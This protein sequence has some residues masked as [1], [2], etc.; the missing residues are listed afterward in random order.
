MCVCMCVCVC[1]CVHVCVCV[2]DNHQPCLTMQVIKITQA[3]EVSIE[4]APYNP[5]LKSCTT[6]TADEVK[7]QPEE[8][9]ERVE[10]LKPV[11]QDLEEDTT[12]PVEPAEPVEP[13]EQNGPVEPQSVV[14][15]VGLYTL[16]LCV[17]F[18]FWYVNGKYDQ[19][20]NV[21]LTK[22]SIMLKVSIAW[23]QL[24]HLY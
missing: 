17:Q 16:L 10:E 15:K 1:V 11:K 24:E 5:H 4:K 18:Y 19:N 7:V 12:K 2:F 3:G 23:V 8:D 6:P 9:K 20:C 21:N 13:V 14:K 22:R